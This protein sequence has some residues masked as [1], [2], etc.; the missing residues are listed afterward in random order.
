M[1]EDGRE[2]HGPGFFANVA[3]FMPSAGYMDP[4]YGNLFSNGTVYKPGVAIEVGNYFRLWHTDKL[5][6]GVRASWLQLGYTKHQDTAYSAG[7]AFGSP[8]RL[9]PQASYLLGENMGIDVFYQIGA[10]YNIDWL[11]GENYS[12]AGLSHE[13]GAALRYTIFTLGFGYRVGSLPNVDTSD[14]KSMP[15]EKDY[16]FS[17]KSMRIFIGIQL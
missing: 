12:Y 9:G 13:F 7:N 1:K 15:L 3:L 2:S 17:V 14:P 8:L 10:Q 4:Y 5:G 11:H 6:L 16:N